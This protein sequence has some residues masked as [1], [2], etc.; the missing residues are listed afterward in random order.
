VHSR[1]NPNIEILNP[2]Q[3]QMTE[4]RM[5]ETQG[6]AKINGFVGFSIWI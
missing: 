3:I 5:P 6:L 1:E 2:K 4:A